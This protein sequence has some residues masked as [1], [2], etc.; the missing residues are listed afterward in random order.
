MKNRIISLLTLLACTSAVAIAQPKARYADTEINLGNIA[1]R[2]A[3][4][5][6]IRLTNAGNRPLYITDVQTDCGCT[7][8]SWS[9]E[10]IT[11]GATA[12]IAV[13]YDAETLGTFGRN[14]S[15]TTN[16]DTEPVDI[17]LTGRVLTEVHDLTNDF[18]HHYDQ[19]YLSTDNIEFDDVNLGDMPEQTIL[20]LNNGQKA[21]SPEFMH[22]PKYLTA[23]A[24]PEV[25]RPGRVG[26]VTFTLDSRQLP[27]MGL[28]QS[29]IYI[30]RYPGDKVRKAG[31]VNVSATLLPQFTE[32]ALRASE[33]P[34]ASIPTTIELS[35]N[36][37]KKKLKGSLTLENHGTAPLHVS[38]LQVYN[39]GISVSLSKSVI[40]P[41]GRA[42]LKITASSAA[43]NFKG[44][45]RILLITDDPTNSKITIDVTAK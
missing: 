45:R 33:K 13:T 32:A 20:V 4:V 30:A 35:G 7:V 23:I 31:E 8:V 37:N 18:T 38:A 12:D 17:L 19:V 25:L 21:Y 41:G 34:Q 5:G 43:D 27:K 3:A 29:S 39:P 16:A 24:R 14:V 10:A 11:P 44:R 42:V 1:W 6:H 36:I 9:H 15:I 28:T 40:R 2:T 26:R 22:L